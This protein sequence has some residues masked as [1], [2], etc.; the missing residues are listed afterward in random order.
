MD[1]GSLVADLGTA[2]FNAKYQQQTPTIQPAFNPLDDIGVPF[3]DVIPQAPNRK[4]WRVNGLQ[5]SM[6]T[7][8]VGQS[9]KASQVT[10]SNSK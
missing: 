8:Q 7:V 10:P 2:Y 3:V 5:K 4:L 6:W 1:L 9:K